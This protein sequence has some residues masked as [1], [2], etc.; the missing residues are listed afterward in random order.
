MVPSEF[1]RRVSQ[2]R[3]RG[4]DH[5]KAGPM[6][7]FGG[8]VKPGLHGEHPSLK[9]LDQGDM[10]P[11]ADFRQLYAAALRWLKVDPKA[12]LGGEFKGVRPLR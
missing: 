10:K 3:S 8:G 6:F 9:D 2:N 7:F 4:T 5:G 11:T 12:V 1:G